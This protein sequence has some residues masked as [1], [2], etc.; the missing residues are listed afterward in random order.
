[1]AW[2]GWRYPW[3]GI[4]GIQEQ[5]LNER[6]D[7]IQNALQIVQNNPEPAHPAPPHAVEI[8][9][10]KRYTRVQTQRKQE[11]ERGKEDALTRRLTATPK[12]LQGWWL[13][14]YLQQHLHHPFCVH[15]HTNRTI[16]NKT[17]GQEPNRI[18]LQIITS[19]LVLLN[20]LYKDPTPSAKHD[21]YWDARDSEAKA[22][23]Q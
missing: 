6:T 18:V 3:A 19:T 17:S 14:S 22:K 2:P 7:M 9:I 10:R 4:P 13:A 21:F 16:G 15:Y 5:L 12:T 11:P 23:K 20:H 1:M 8:T